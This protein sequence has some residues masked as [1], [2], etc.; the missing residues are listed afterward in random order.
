M[1]SA[2]DPALMGTLTLH[3]RKKQLELTL[4]E[5]DGEALFGEVAEARFASLAA[6]L[7]VEPVVRVA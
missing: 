7:D 4:P 6:S 1:F 3:P 5:G 2:Q